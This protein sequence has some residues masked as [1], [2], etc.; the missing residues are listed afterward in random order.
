MI[1][2][3]Y[4]PGHPVDVGLYSKPPRSTV[5]TCYRAYRFISLA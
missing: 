4:G 2:Y 5:R 1:P 3:I